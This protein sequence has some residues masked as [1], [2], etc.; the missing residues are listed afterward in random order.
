MPPGSDTAERAG[1]VLA[2]L[3]GGT[4]ADAPAIV[5]P[6]DR[7]ERSYS[8]LIDV[9]TRQAGV[10]SAAGVARGDC[11]ALVLPNGPEIVET[12]LALSLLGAA[13]APL[14]PAYTVDEFAFYLDDL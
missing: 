8:E 7:T 13:A 1:E 12:V 3:L 5:C 14:N 6:E 4:P 2:E 9:V 11:V 10:L